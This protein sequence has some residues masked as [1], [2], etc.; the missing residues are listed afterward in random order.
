M[1]VVAVLPPSP[2]V[3][4]GGPAGD[5]KRGYNI[6]GKMQV[7]TV[8]SLGGSLVMVIMTGTKGVFQVV[9][10]S[11]FFGVPT[12]KERDMKTERKR[13]REREKKIK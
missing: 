8:L 1:T 9:L 6:V 7:I 13:K 12:G 4:E 10:V 5:F 11:F 2:F 3:L